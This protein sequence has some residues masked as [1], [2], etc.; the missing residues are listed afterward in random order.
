MYFRL[1]NR[2]F[3]IV[4]LMVSVAI[5][6][7]LS[8]VVYTNFNESRALARDKQRIA[9]LSQVQL[10]LELYKNQYGRYPEQGCGSVGTTY[11]GPGPD[12]QIR[13]QQCTGSCVQYISGA[14]S[15]PF[16]PE[17][18]SS[19]PLDPVF[20]NAA[21]FDKGFYYRTDAGGT[22]YKLFIMESLEEM[23]IEAGDD[24]AICP[25]IAGCVA[26]GAGLLADYTTSIGIYTAGA[27]QW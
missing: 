8:A 17:F 5:I 6:G 27:E 22:A 3:T 12:N 2:G 19:L 18:M 14:A 21:T 7:I 1:G 10:A 9:S 25:V 20:D 4:E 24:F 15:T 16:V 11:C 13:L 26:T 23:T